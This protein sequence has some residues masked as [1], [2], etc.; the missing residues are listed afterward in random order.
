MVS[1][2]AVKLL[3]LEGHFGIERCRHS[4]FCQLW[5]IWYNTMPKGIKQ[6]QVILI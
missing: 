2:E 1:I 5:T 6:M 3:K 4:K